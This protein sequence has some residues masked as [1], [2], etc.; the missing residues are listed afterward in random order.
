MK[1]IMG[2]M[3]S[4]TLVWA[5]VFAPA[6]SAQSGGGDKGDWSA[7]QALPVAT[8][9]V[10]KTKGG[11]TIKGFFKKADAERLELSTQKGADASLARGEVQKVYLAKRRSKS[12]VV[13]L[14][15]L[16]GAGIGFGIGLGATFKA[17]QNSD[18]TPAAVLFTI[19]GAGAGALVGSAAG[20]SV[21]KGRLI[22]ESK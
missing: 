17:A 18:P 22:Y 19:Y 13:K 11:A 12:R 6:A 9:L 10:V 2:W 5:S 16:I 15:A 3:L 8:D 1:K 4:M 7:V 21:R 20:E 14:G